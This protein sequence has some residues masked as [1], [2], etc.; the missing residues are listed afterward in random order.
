MAYTALSLWVVGA[1]AQA[2]QRMAQTLELA[3][4]LAHPFSLTYVLFFA[5]MLAQF[6]RQAAAVQERAATLMALASQQGF[7]FYLD[8]GR[9]LHGWALTVQGQA[10]AGLAQL[11]QGLATSHATQG[12]VAHHYFV[13]LLADAHGACGHRAE[14]LRLVAEALAAVPRSGRFWEA[15]LY[16]QRGDLL[17]RDNPTAHATEAEACWQ[18]ARRIAQRQG[19]RALELR[20]AMRLSRLWQQQG[21]PAEAHALLAP[22]YDGFTEGFE[23]ADLQEARALLEVLA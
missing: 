23:T 2:H 6:Q 22:V 16:R 19:A 14:G 12:V 11:Q 1:P 9:M 15:E 20:A 7:P 21:K 18:Q 17:L 5:A 4:A 8:L 13:A 10:D 3:Y